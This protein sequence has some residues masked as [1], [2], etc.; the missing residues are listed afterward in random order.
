MEDFVTIRVR[1]LL[2]VQRAILGVVPAALREVSCGWRGTEIT[3][4]FVFDGEIEPD[5]QEG[6][7][8]A[9]AEVIADFSAPWT[10]FEEIVRIDYPAD[11]RGSRGVNMLLAYQRKERSSSG[12]PMPP[13]SFQAAR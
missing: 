3:V 6:V 13:S 8:I 10:I 1:L 4:R 12:E 7:M 5:D 11:L 2:S 9:G